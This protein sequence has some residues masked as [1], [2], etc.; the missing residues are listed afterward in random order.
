MGYQP[1]LDGI[2]AVSVIIVILYHA[3][4]SWMHGGFFGVEVFFVVSG[5][6]IT[7]LLLDERATTG[8][9][10]LQQF[11]VRRAR[12]LLPAL[13][14]ML[15][16]VSLWA[17]FFGDEHLDQ[18]GK[19]MLPSIFYVS[20]WAQIFGGVP[21]FAAADPPLL[22]HL[23]SLAVEEQWYL[24]WPLV[25]VGL[26]RLAARRP[27]GGGGRLAV[28]LLVASVASMLFS[29]LLTLSDSLTLTVLWWEPLRYN[30][31]YLN[32]ISRAS[33][34]LLGAAF[35]FFWRPWRWS[36]AAQIERRGL[37]VVGLGA[38][39][40][41]VVIAATRAADVLV[42]ASMYRVW[43]PLVTV[44]SMVVVA[45]VVHPGARLTRQVFGWTPLV[46]IG[47][48]SY[49][50]YLWHWPIF[51]FADVSGNQVRFWWAAILTIVVS[52]LCYR[53][54][55]TPIRK[56]AIGRL[57]ATLGGGDSGRRSVLA[58]FVSVALLFLGGTLGLAMVRADP[59]NIAVD[60]TEV[61]FGFD[62]DAVQPTDTG[63]TSPDD[64][65]PGGAGVT[66]PGGTDD[67][68]QVPVT[69]PV[70]TDGPTTTAP[71][72]P[73]DVIIV[74]DS[75]AHSLAV[76]L[77]A[78]IEDTFTISNGSKDGCG[79]LTDGDVRSE[80]TSFG[81]SFTDC[82]GFADEWA[83]DASAKGAEVALVVLGAWDV[84]DVEVDG[85]LVPFASAE[86]DRRFLAGLQTG[87][88][89][90]RGVGTH[91]ALLEIACMR[92]VE[93]DGAFVPPL[94]ERGDDERITHLNG[95]LRQAV[96]DNPGGDVSFVP[97]PTEWCNDEVIATDL[98]YRWDGVHVYKPGANLIFT[99]VAPTLLQIPL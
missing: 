66:T 33:G 31:L 22:R 91:V 36:R 18:L 83:R 43:L 54:V 93:A 25:F 28:G 53:F 49:G 72:L 8:G 84:F 88:D 97:G 37:D 96:A 98:G 42:S 40:I 61:E 10:S 47:K 51:V 26:W 78:G 20:N 65:S 82:A 73:R 4:F 75:Q 24:I 7:S 90:L 48:R 58:G 56:G 99:T 23:W 77:P 13:F 21:Y 3:G 45:V 70:T 76:N 62:V 19:D 27:R 35:A 63:E 95:L 30:F 74:G 81:R 15:L 11:W 5:F 16:A 44:L 60:D 46:E 29:A 57:W 59:V 32:T 67:G 71:T 80:R 85:A 9:V 55:E 92:P 34:L 2:R 79:V 52:E 86:S 64:T 12:R 89:A 6:L 68:S 50:L 17:A 38:M 14:A 41:V 1:G 69:D 39:V 87:I 94:P